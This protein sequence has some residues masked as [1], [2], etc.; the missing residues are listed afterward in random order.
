MYQSLSAP[1]RQ[2]WSTYDAEKMDGL[3]LSVQVVGRRFEE[4]KV[5]AG[6]RV[7]EAALK[8]KNVLF[9]GKKDAV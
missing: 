1:A 8:K 4:E 3:P 6:M 7:I 2:A 5:F 9:I